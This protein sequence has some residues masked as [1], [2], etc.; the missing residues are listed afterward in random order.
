MKAGGILALAGLLAGCAH[1]PPISPG[2]EYVALGSSYA[3]GTGMGG[4]KPGT[5]ERC[6]R[7]PL[8]YATL[9]AAGLHLRLVDAS[10][11]G[12]MTA[13]LLGPWNELPPQLDALTPQTRLVT[14]TGAGNDIGFVR[15]LAA[16]ACAQGTAGCPARLDPVEADWRA[17][18]L[19]LQ[20]VVDRIRERAPSA[21]IVF[22]DYVTL[23]PAHGT[24]AALGMSTG[25]ADTARTVAKRLAAVTARVAHHNGADLIA[26]SRLSASHTPCDPV[27][28]S[29]GAPGSASST[30]WHPNAA[31]HAAIAAELERLLAGRT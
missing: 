15:N 7:S 29:M 9:L 18:E 24:C 13:H 21:R 17:V 2:A 12:A 26:A 14:I 19:A 3:A 20:Q 28:W 10:C 8:N 16:S 30:P 31:G 22:V 23:I 11:G 4:I 27:P 6:Q 1:V 5:P 25:D